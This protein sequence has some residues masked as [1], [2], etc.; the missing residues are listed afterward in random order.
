MNTHLRYAPVKFN[1]ELPEDIFYQALIGKNTEFQNYT[2]CDKTGKYTG[3]IIGKMERLHPVSGIQYFPSFK[4][5]DSFYISFVRS[6][7]K[8]M[9]TKLLNFASMISKKM[10]GGGKFHLIASERYSTKPIPPHIFYRKYGMNSLESDL[11][12]KIDRYL[13]GK[14]CLE[15]IDFYDTPMYFIP[16]KNGQSAKKLPVLKKLLRL[17]KI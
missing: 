5:E 10:G 7:K 17:F 2:A 1:K 8:G 14:M 9:G 3:K 12:F 15:N 13:K 6:H 11:I 16:R 4:S